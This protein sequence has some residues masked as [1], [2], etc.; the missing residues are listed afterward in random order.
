M[1]G[2]DILLQAMI[3]LEDKYKLT[4][5]GDGI[6]REKYEE[7]IKK[8][9]LEASISLKGI[10]D[11][12]YLKDYLDGVD[13]LCLPSR[14]EGFNISALEANACGVPVVATNVGGFHEFIV[15]GF[16]GYLC[17]PESPS[18]LADIIEKT[19]KKEW[20]NQAIADWTEQNYGWDKY[21]INLFNLIKEKLCAVSAE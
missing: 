8:N 5:I 15:N 11:H 13:L 1:K 9:K 20:D 3:F 21:A 12:S 6:L 2:H 7:F 10:I 17:E 14:S 4:L 19:A 18:V 16:N